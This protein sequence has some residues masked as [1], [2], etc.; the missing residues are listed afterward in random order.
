LRVFAA[1]HEKEWEGVG[2][3]EG[4]HIWRIENLNVVKWAT[5]EYG[6]FCT[7]D[8]Y[9]VL[10][11]YKVENKLENVIF[12]W[13]GKESSQDE[14]TVAAYKTVELDDLLGGSATQH[15]EIEGG[16]T[17]D[18]IDVFNTK[19][20]HFNVKKGGI[21][22][23]FHHVEAEKYTPVL[24]HVEGKKSPKIYE[25]ELSGKN[26]NISDP[27]IL[28]TGLKLFFWKPKKATHEENF[29]T[30]VYLTK[31]KDQR[32]GASIIEVQ[33]DGSEEF[34]KV[35]GGKPEVISEAKK[36]D[37]SDKSLKLFNYD[38]K[39][40]KFVLIEKDNITH[41]SLDSDSLMIIDCY[42]RFFVWCGKGLKKEHHH[43]GIIV[44]NDYLKL[45][46]R[47]IP[48][49]KVHD[50]KEPKSFFDIINK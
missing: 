40:N 46:K 18:F 23:G 43:Y 24:L 41:D 42:H 10:R 20:L 7:G 1:K 21:A 48:F 3:D 4:L 34:W 32:K 27:F 37:N 6:N 11:S 25:E 50:G 8:S 31:L 28:D 49:G 47:N 22:S 9:I 19:T 45:T 30:S 12:F 39:D 33:E 5:K 13:I 15:R 35:L 14:Y 38:L 36:N 26:L 16:E 44:G 2:K 17:T 29:F